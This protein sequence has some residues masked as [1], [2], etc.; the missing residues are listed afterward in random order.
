MRDSEDE[1]RLGCL[2]LWCLWLVLPLQTGLVGRGHGN[3]SS[4]PA[5]CNIFRIWWTIKSI[6]TANGTQKPNSQ[7][8]FKAA[9]EHKTNLKIFSVK[10][11]QSEKIIITEKAQHTIGI[12]VMLV[13]VYSSNFFSK[14]CRLERKIFCSVPPPNQHLAQI[15]RLVNNGKP[16]CVQDWRMPQK[17]LKETT[18]ARK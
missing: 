12:L 11:A 3:S 9:A 10:P 16:W 18:T 7:N 17:Q 5:P 2:P 1:L 15:Q 8:Q 6:A 4:S 13:L 14:L